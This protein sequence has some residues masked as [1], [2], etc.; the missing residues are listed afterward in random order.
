MI[1]YKYD[2]LPRKELLR[3]ASPISNSLDYSVS[4]KMPQ[5]MSVYT[6]TDFVSSIYN[7]CMFHWAHTVQRHIKSRPLPSDPL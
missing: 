4:R 1:N 6:L 7:I 3:T 5:V 2:G